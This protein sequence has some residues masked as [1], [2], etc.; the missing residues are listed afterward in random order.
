MRKAQQT[1]R[2]DQKDQYVPASLGGR[3]CS[4]WQTGPPASP[5]PRDG[6]QVWGKIH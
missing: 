2:E 6:G 5:E 4:G 1:K 3:F